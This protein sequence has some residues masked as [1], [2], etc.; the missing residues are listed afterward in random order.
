VLFSWI[1][2]RTTRPYTGTDKQRQHRFERVLGPE[3]L[4]LIFLQTR[5]DSR[6]LEDRVAL[7]YEIKAAM[8][9]RPAMVVVPSDA[10]VA[11]RLRGFLYTSPHATAAELEGN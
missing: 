2:A 7:C 10:Q 11:A 5:K 8:E 6:L 1:N 3:V 4:T 9:G